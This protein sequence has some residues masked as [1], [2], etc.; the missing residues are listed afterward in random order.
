MAKMNDLQ[1]WHEQAKADLLAAKGKL[2]NAQEEVQMIEQKIESLESLYILE[3]GNPDKI[4]MIA[5]NN[6]DEVLAT[7]E[8]ILKAEGKPMHIGDL[9]TALIASG[10]V[11]PGKGNDANLIAKFQ[12]SKGRIVRTSRGFYFLGDQES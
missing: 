4:Q 3:G 12:R 6:A 7:A 8:E 9:R 1:N 5:K 2:R 11:L 10:V